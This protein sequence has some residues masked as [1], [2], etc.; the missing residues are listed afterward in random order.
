MLCRA[1][2]RWACSSLLSLAI[3]DLR[4]KIQYQLSGPLSNCCLLCIWLLPLFV[5]KISSKLGLDRTPYHVLSLPSGLREGGGICKAVS[6]RSL[7]QD[8]LSSC[9]SLELMA[10]PSASEDW[11]VNTPPSARFRTN[12]R[13]LVRSGSIADMKYWY[14]HWKQFLC[15]QVMHAAQASPPLLL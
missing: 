9:S 2:R 14:T 5:E 6:F 7:A 15:S 13:Q 8:P 11:D 3:A 10:L 4:I 12:I 1:L